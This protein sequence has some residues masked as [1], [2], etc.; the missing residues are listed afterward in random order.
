MP[1]DIVLPDAAKAV[2][3]AAE[4]LSADPAILS[5]IRKASAQSGARFDVM[6]A[7]AQLESGL[8]PNAASR[9]SS[10]KGLFQ[11]V[12]QTW[13][14]TV[15]QFGASHG[16]AS[17]A[18]AVVRRGSELTVDDPA[19]RQRILALR[20]NPTIASELAGDHLRSIADNLTTTL[21]RPPDA[22]E[23]YLG[24]FLGS[25]GAGQMLQALQSTPNRTAADLLPRAAAANPGMFRSRSGA[26]YTVA[27]FMAHLRSRVAAV[28]AQLG[29]AMPQSQLGV[30]AL[31]APSPAASTVAIGGS[32]GGSAALLHVRRPMQEQMMGTLID[33][34]T[35]L[36]RDNSSAAQHRNVQSLPQVVLSALQSGPATA[37]LPAS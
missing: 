12:D 22:S 27:Q 24:H 14:S 1:F 36:D 31:Q 3:P 35:R 11:F 23:I 26:P 9:S 17:E 30:D 37:S 13:L 4:P 25:A 28:F 10:A 16:L 18:A 15:R 33:L 32:A 34:L 19:L 20:D 7:S 29:T 21:G 6:L 2:A 8:D 5:A